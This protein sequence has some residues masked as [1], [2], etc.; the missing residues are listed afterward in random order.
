MRKEY[1]IRCWHKKSLPRQETDCN[2]YTSGTCVRH[3]DNQWN[4]STMAQAL[5]IQ[6]IHAVDHPSHETHIFN[7][8]GEEVFGDKVALL[9]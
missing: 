3:C 4:V 6:N 5:Q 2:T 1:E 7:E 9:A 8:E